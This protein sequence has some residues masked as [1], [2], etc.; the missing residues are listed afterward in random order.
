MQ[1]FWK[2][3]DRALSGTI[4]LIVAALAMAGALQVFSRYVLGSAFSWTEELSRFLLIWLV[5]IAAAAEV[6]RG[7]HICVT[8]LTDKFSLASRRR[9]DQASFVLILVFAMV[10]AVFGY[11]LSMRTMAQ[12]ATT[13]PVSI[14]AVYLAL[15]IGGVLMAINALRSLVGGREHPDGSRQEVI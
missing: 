7:G 5:V 1:Q 8:M 14:G 4:I 2:Q 3:F 9:L 12:S 6:H 13:I 15:P 10:L 11:Q